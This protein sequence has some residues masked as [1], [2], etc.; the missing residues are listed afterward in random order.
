VSTIAIVGCVGVPARYGGFETLAE[1]LVRYRRNHD[2]SS[3]LLV[4]CTARGTAQRPAG[5]LGAELRYVSLPANGVGSIAY[6]SVSLLSA[7]NERVDVIVVLGVSGALALPFVRLISHARIITNI[8]GIEWRRAKWHG[9]A[10][11]F[12][13]FSEWLAVHL[14]HVVVADN[15]A[16]A[17]YVKQRYHKV[18]EV[19]PY[20]GDHALSRGTGEVRLPALPPRYALSICR[21]EPENNVELILGVFAQLPARALVFVGNWSAS[22]YGRKLKRCFGANANLHLL[23]PVYDTASL[24]ALRAEA[25]L[26]VHGHSAGGTNPSLVEIMHFGCPVLAYDCTFNRSTTENKALFFRDAQ[27]LC[28]EIESLAPEHLASVGRE[29]REV[30]QR[31]YTWGKIG[32]QYFQLF[33]C[34]GGVDNPA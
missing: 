8:D 14:S 31:R 7:V 4:Y 22:N 29:L 18:C 2:K 33:G 34:T 5:Y 25:G 6:D 26:Y 13:H 24:H 19:I 20:G 23:D 21:V 17:V 30:A 9:P 10:R 27:Q 15:E 11:W 12:L 1:N 3:R 28:N 16:I 32:A